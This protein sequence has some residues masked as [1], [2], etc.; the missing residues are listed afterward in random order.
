[1]FGRYAAQ[2]W[3][4]AVDFSPAYVGYG[5]IIGPSVS[6]YMLVGAI[7]GWGILSPVAKSKGWAPGPVHEFDHGSRG[8]ILWVGMGLILGDTIISLGWIIF[9][10]LILK[11]QP[12]VIRFLQPRTKPTAAIPDDRVPLLGGDLR[13]HDIG[14]SVDCGVEDDD[15]QITSLVTAPLVLWIAVAITG[16]YLLCVLIS[17]GEL[18]STFATIVAAL[19]IPVFGFMSM[20]SLGETDNGAGLAIGKLYN[21]KH[22]H[23]SASWRLK[24]SV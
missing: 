12:T 9:K 10:P 5:I 23:H 4:W 20:R 7:I 16:L 18:V 8:W 2:T 6:A 17:F 3:L 14:E 22:S 24:Y 21:L 11:I 19:S 1:M 15:W 13:T